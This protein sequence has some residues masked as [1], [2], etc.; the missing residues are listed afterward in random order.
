[1]ANRTFDQYD[2]SILKRVCHVWGVF[3]MNGTTPVLQRWNYPTL[4]T[5][6]NARTYSAAPTPASAGASVGPFNHYSAGAD[7]V[8]S[9][10][11]TGAGLWTVQLQDNYQ[12]LLSVKVS[13]SLAGGLGNIVQAHE[14]SSISNMPAS[15][16]SIIGLALLSASGAA[17]DPT[18]SSYVRVEFA[19]QDATEP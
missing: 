19:L 3:Q 16:G 5:G 11:R 13:Q 8:W 7:G 6:V 9:V 14:N 18:A 17:A 1:M 10:T 15:G 12:R 4:G 2:L